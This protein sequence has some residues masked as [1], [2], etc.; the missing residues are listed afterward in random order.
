MRESL[1]RS[2]Q[3]GG[4]FW[5]L[6]AYNLRLY[7]E[8]RGREFRFF[9]SRVHLYDRAQEI[10]VISHVVLHCAVGLMG[11]HTDVGEATI[12]VDHGFPHSKYQD[13]R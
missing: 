1:E 9:T 12:Q 11:S 7:A 2:R 13:A 6:F 8:Q 3:V 10:L 4:A 5:R